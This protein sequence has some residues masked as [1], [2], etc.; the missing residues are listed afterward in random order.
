MFNTEANRPPYRKFLH[1]TLWVTFPFFNMGSVDPCNDN[2]ATNWVEVI[3]VY[4]AINNKGG[5][6]TSTTQSMDGVKDELGTDVLFDDV[7]NQP[8]QK[9]IHNVLPFDL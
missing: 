1:L 6:E 3:E 2:S 9:K 4:V 5:K 7:V 8:K